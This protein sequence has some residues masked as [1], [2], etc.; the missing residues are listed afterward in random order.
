MSSLRFQQR[1]HA[2]MFEAKSLA[3]THVVSRGIFYACQFTT[4]VRVDDEINADL[5]LPLDIAALEVLRPQVMRFRRPL[6]AQMVLRIAFP[7]RSIADDQPSIEEAIA[8]TTVIAV[9]E[10]AAF[11]MTQVCSLAALQSDSRSAFT[12]QLNKCDDLSSAGLHDEQ[13]LDRLTAAFDFIDVI[14]LFRPSRFY[15]RECLYN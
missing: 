2:L 15:G 14:R 5:P 9:R 10:P 7:A 8:S 3:Q 11:I 12:A 6:F 1:C 13:I 4:A